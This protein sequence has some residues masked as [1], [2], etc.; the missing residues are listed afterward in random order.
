MPKKSASLDQDPWDDLE[1]DEPFQ[2]VSDTGALIVLRKDVLQNPELSLGAIGV[3]AY[4]CS[5]WQREDRTPSVEELV[6]AKRGSTRKE[7]R[8]HLR[9]LAANGVTEYGIF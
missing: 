9:E 8:S 1:D 6:K 3:Y 5:C 4:L 7:I 2:V